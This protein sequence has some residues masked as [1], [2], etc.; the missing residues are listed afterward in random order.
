LQINSVARV[1]ELILASPENARRPVM[2]L[3]KKAKKNGEI[4]GA[5]EVKIVFSK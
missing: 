2:P 5:S 1:P 4:A 3:S